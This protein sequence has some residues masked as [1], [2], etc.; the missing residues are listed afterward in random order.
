MV[1]MVD[2]Y[3]EFSHPEEMLRA[4]SK[5]LKATGQIALAEFRAEDPNVPIKPLHKMSKN[6]IF[7]EF[8]A[9][10]FRLVRQFD[11]LPWQHLMFFVREDSP[12]AA[13]PTEIATPTAPSK[14]APAKTSP[15][16]TAPAE[17]APA[18]PRRAE[19]APAETAP[20][21]TGQKA[22]LP[23]LKVRVLDKD[24]QPVTGAAV[25]VYDRNNYFAG[26]PVDFEQ[27]SELTDREGWVDFGTMPQDYL[28]V[29]VQ[30]REGEYFGSHSVIYR[31]EQGF[32]Q[33]NP[34]RPAVKLATD[35][36]SLCVTF[37]VRMGVDLK[38]EVT[39]AGTGE[40]IF[41]PNIYY[42]D[43][44]LKRWW[45][46][47]LIDAG[48]QHDFITIVPELSGVQLRAAAVG[49]YPLNFNLDQRL[50]VGKEFTRKIQ[51]KPAPEIR[52][53]VF[54]PDGKPAKARGSA[55]STQRASAIS[56]QPKRS[57]TNAVR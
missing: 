32:V 57:P 2:V 21:E 48:G 8:R 47:A 3:H 46:I 40:P 52:F 53:T 10:G 14:T 15:A 19:T 45:T 28:C 41:F 23:N 29:Q 56:S 51:L 31:G 1:L 38:F 49:Y 18:K 16:K 36:T 44:Q 20:A 22:P 24:A 34:D 43:E 42:W 17:T 9:N 11:D 50:E 54:T 25:L 35:E 13:T 4:I 5:S 26:Q 27:R 33:T 30:P 55:A 12:V 7:K 39:D 6:Q 37:T